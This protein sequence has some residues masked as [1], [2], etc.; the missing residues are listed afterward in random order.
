M[1]DRPGPFAQR[2]ILL[3]AALVLLPSAAPVATGEVSVTV[4]GLRSA[5][6]LLRACMT[7]EA[8]DFPKCEDP[9]H[10]LSVSVNAAGTVTLSF[11]DVA[12]GRYAIAL[13]HDENANG[14]MDRSLLIPREGFGF[15]RDAEVSLGPPKFR[16]AA[17]DVAGGEREHLLIHMRYMF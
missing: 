8:T 15:S 7:D 12:A 10:D 6:G 2:L 9:K 11:P 17:F 5:K 16:K 4:V 1:R 14:K 3:P 13:L